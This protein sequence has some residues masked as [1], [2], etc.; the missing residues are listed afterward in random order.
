MDCAGYSYRDGGAVLI[1]AA[2]V[3]RCISSSVP[4]SVDKFCAVDL[5]SSNGSEARF[6][7]ELKSDFTSK[8][9]CWVLLN[10]FT[11]QIY[12]CYNIEGYRKSGGY[13]VLGVGR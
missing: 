10:Y 8:T 11:S 1:C 4:Q 7:T 3:L 6:C 5:F 9:C 12:N 2:S 13:D